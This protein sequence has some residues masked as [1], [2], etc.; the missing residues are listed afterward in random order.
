MAVATT[1]STTKYAD[2]L[3]HKAQCYANA[4]RL[5]ALMMRTRSVG[6]PEA[7]YQFAM[8]METVFT[9]KA[10]LEDDFAKRLT[11]RPI[12]TLREEGLI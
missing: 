7:E 10:K 8:T 1:D 9:T 6:L 3:R 12:E 2:E 5:A 11:E 4:F